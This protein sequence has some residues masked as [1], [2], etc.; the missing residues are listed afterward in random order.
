MKVFLIFI[1]II[2]IYIFIFYKKSNFWKFE[3]V[4]SKKIGIIKSNLL[5]NEN[6]FNL[7]IIENNIPQ[8]IQNLYKNLYYKKNSF[9]ISNLP[10]KFKLFILKKYNN[11][12]GSII[13]IHHPI[14][15]NNIFYNSYYVDYLLINN[16]YR[17]KDY[18]K[19]L[20]KKCVN[21]LFEKENIL[22][23]FFKIDIKKLPFDNFYKED[24]YYYNKNTFEK[25]KLLYDFK[26]I[27]IE[28]NN[29]NLFLKNEY[30]KKFQI[31]S[32]LNFNLINQKINNNEIFILNFK[33]YFI[34]CLFKIYCDKKYI[35]IIYI[36]QKTPLF[37]FYNFLKYLFID[38]TEIFIY[39]KNNN[40]KEFG[41]KYEYSVN[42]YLYNYKIQN[43]E[44]KLLLI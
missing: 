1:F 26:N 16:K 27:K 13:F 41:L 17:N 2:F 24:V 22:I 44:N 5:F 8:N 32:F 14:F 15:I 10:S 39:L 43:V 31:K 3:P 20:I 29:V 6:N 21:Y 38:Y 33:N 19:I 7:Q 18:V 34:I 37:I 40:Y 36:S 30:N 23:Y 35:E 12:I 4:H 11:I 9:N 25:I 42:Y 28:K